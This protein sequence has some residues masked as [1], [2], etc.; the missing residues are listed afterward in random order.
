V[1]RKAGAA[2]V[3]ALGLL[4]VSSPAQAHNPDLMLKCAAVSGG[5]GLLLG[6]LAGVLAA[7]RMSPG[8]S[9]LARMRLGLLVAYAVSAV[10]PPGTFFG[11]ITLYRWPG[12]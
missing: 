10:L 11:M 6:G 5:A 7:A 3:A 9:I 1:R 4:L 12:G 8:N 2:A